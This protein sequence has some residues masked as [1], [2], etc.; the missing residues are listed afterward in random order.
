MAEPVSRN[1]QT[2]SAKPVRLDPTSDTGWPTH[3]VTKVR[4]K[5]VIRST[6]SRGVRSE[7]SDRTLRRKCRGAMSSSPNRRF[8]HRSTRRS[9]ARSHSGKSNHDRNEYPPHLVA[10]ITTS[11][12]GLIPIE[13]PTEMMVVKKA[14]R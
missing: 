12:V 8:A 5:R 11:K 13:V 4:L 1:T 3:T 10:G 6:G 7:P 14:G 9:H 2:A